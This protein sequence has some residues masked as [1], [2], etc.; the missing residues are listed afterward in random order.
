MQPNYIAAF[1]TMACPRG[2]PYCLNELGGEVARYKISS[3]EKWVPALNRLDCDVPITLHGGEPLYHPD[4]YEIVNHIRPESSMDMLTTFPYGVDEFC[5]KIRPERFHNPFRYPSIRV[6]HHFDSMNLE[7]TI[8][9]VLRLRANGYSVGLYFV[10]HPGMKERIDDAS[11][12]CGSK[13]LTPVLKP[14][15]GMHDNRVY[16]Y[17]KYDQACFSSALHR[18]SCRSSNLLVAPDGGVYGCHKGLFG[19][20]PLL[21]TGNLF[22]EYEFDKVVDCPHYG[23]CN[24]CDVQYKYDKEGNWGFSA[25]TITGDI[26]KTSSFDE[27]D[28][29]LP[30]HC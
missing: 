29:S 2:C 11:R 3:A 12:H 16:G 25:V 23:D 7:E 18:V 15:L 8:D 5:S 27:S 14:Y 1:L 28:W 4:F 19:K 17:Y 6:T 9:N 26:V 24:A 30:D 21:S 20:I 13:G 10:R 22:G